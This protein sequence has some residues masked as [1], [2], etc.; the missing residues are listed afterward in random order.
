MFRSPGQREYQRDTSRRLKGAGRVDGEGGNSP[1]RKEPQNKARLS[2]CRVWRYVL[3]SE[4][5]MSACPPCGPVL[6]AW[7][8]LLRRI[9][10]VCLGG[11]IQS[12][13]YSARFIWGEGRGGLNVL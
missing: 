6:G 3:T 5:R 1:T 4:G 12:I 11:V 2:T 9:A 13:Q 10:F 8:L 7:S